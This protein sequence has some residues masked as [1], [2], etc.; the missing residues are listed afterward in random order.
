MNSIEDIFDNSN[1]LIDGIHHFFDRYIGNSLLRKSGIHKIVDKIMSKGYEY[2][3]SPLLRL[4]LGK[5]DR[6]PSPVSP[7]PVS[8]LLT[9]IKYPS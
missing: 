7:S 2:P 4:S 9:R 5:R 8:P 1:Q 6:E 3:D